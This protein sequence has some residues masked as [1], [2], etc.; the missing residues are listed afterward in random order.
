MPVSILSMA[1][2]ATTKS[3][4][5]AHISVSPLASDDFKV[6][7]YWYD[8]ALLPQLPL[9]IPEADAQTEPFDRKAAEKRAKEIVAL[10]NFSW[11]RYWSF[12]EPPFST[13][14][15]QEEAQFWLEWFNEVGEK[16]DGSSSATREENQ[17]APYHS[18]LPIGL[19]T[20]LDFAAGTGLVDYL[21]QRYSKSMM[22]ESSPEA[23]F[24]AL[25]LIWDRLPEE[26][27]QKITDAVAARPTEWAEMAL[28]QVR[29][30]NQDKIQQTIDDK[31]AEGSD[32]TY[33]DEIETA[34]WADTVEKRV[35]L[36]EKHKLTPVYGDTFLA[37]LASTK[38]AGQGALLRRMEQ[39]TI[40]DVK[41]LWDIL[42]KRVS[43]P[44]A[45]PMIV[46]IAK[47][48]HAEE[49]NTWLRGHIDEVLAADLSAEEV[50][51]I[52][53]LIRGLGADALREVTGK[54][55]PAMN[56]L[57]DDLI[58]EADLLEFDPETSWWK[59]AVAAAA[60]IYGD[61]KPKKLPTIAQPAALPP[62]VFDGQRLG[63]A[64]VETLLQALRTTDRTHPLLTA[65][66]E[67][68][69]A[70]TLDSYSLVV[71]NQWID[72]GAPAKDNWMMVGAGA[73]GGDD[74][75]L[76]LTPLIR[77][78]P[79]ESQHKRATYG[80][81]ALRNVGSNLALQ[82][83]SG[84]AQ[85]VKFAAIK[86]RAGEA[87][88]EI[89]EDLGLSRDELEDR[90]MPDGGLDEHGRRVFSYGPRSFVAM[91]TPECKVVTRL[92]DEDGRP[93][94]KPKASLP[95]PN[96]SDD[97][98]LAAAAKKEYG[99]LKKA[100]T[101][102][103]KNQVIR[104]ED[105][106]VSGRSWSAE[107]FKQY[108]APNPLVRSLLAGVVWGVYTA[109]QRTALARLDDQGALVDV[110]DEP[111]E[112]SDSARVRIVH[113]LDLSEEEKTAWSEIHADFE[114]QEAFPQL[115]RVVYALPAEQGDRLE[116]ADVSQAEID[117][118]SLAGPPK[119]HGW[120]RGDAYDN[121]TFKV[122]IRYFESAD[123]TAVIKHEGLSIDLEFGADGA[124][125]ESVYLVRGEKTT[126]AIEWGEKSP[127]AYT[128]PGDVPEGWE[129]A[130]W[131]EIPAAV[132][133]EIIGTVRDMGA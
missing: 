126:G 123:V 80:L 59:K 9:E 14:P 120:Q 85:K 130:T 3:T 46:A 15:T 89:S 128:S 114:L 82:Q 13:F 95:K 8:Q 129:F 91:L 21:V 37:W 104:F 58:A 60:E 118:Y 109:G 25:R 73:I 6:E 116:L 121:G 100:L 87:M 79:G 97:E 99:L 43:G 101:T 93:T 39:D 49:A 53:P 52:K 86:K 41:P 34:F 28:W 119:K 78:W 31:L 61:K 12:T 64:E 26:D 117:K 92:L 105:A 69:P 4:D 110:N 29:G 55:Q 113:P 66:R 81:D 133:S 124:V 10:R 40:D 77:K 75:V 103:A 54:C 112:L 94:G 65:L 76:T 131:Q 16:R 44:G 71:L 63:I 132:A 36:A 42:H 62:L 83:I 2:K 27:R 68:V 57:V 125:I 96:K 24:L 47:T 106:M 5:N 1:K 11:S 88:E 72:G 102:A 7:L 67:H 38:A 111:V 51:S 127:S 90:I 35:A 74:F 20:V 122:F 70:N 108:L 84:I 22:Y 23:A 30:E 32:T 48:K 98:E 107:E 115:S 19:R 50:D 56:A 33:F 17:W 45:V 18:A